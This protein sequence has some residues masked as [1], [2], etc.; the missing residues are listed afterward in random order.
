MLGTR[1]Q[2][3]QA[4]KKEECRCFEVL[5]LFSVSHTQSQEKPKR[6][7][8]MRNAKDRKEKKSVSVGG[9][10]QKKERRMRDEF[11]YVRPPSTVKETSECVMGMS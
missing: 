11:I 8:E 1:I 2:N 10:G 3:K 9:G 6:S 7:K 5:S 4:R